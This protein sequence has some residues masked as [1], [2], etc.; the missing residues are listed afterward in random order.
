ML[1]YS[2]LTYA[3]NGAAFHV[4]NKLGHGFLEA[5]YQEALEIEFQRRNIPY[6]REKELKIT[7]DGVE[8]K[9]AYKADFVCY[10]KIIIELK[11]VSALDDAHRSQ[12][13]NYQV[14]NYLHATGFKLGLLYNFGCPDELEYERKVL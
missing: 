8:L 12:V 14:Y 9:Q 4:Y 2:D 10:G 11:A 6:E 13:Y 3:I 1:L 5:V 7:Y